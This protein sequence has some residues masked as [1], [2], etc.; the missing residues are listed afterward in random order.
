MIRYREIIPLIIAFLIVSPAMLSGAN[1][2]EKKTSPLELVHSD[3]LEIRQYDDNVILNLT[4]NVHFKQDST[5]IK[6]QRAVWYKTSGVV[7][8]IDSVFLDDGKGNTINSRRATYY[9]NS[10]KVTVS[11]DVLMVAD[12]GR[13]RITGRKGEYLRDREYAI[14]SGEP[15]LTARSEKDTSTV[16]ITARLLE[17][18]D[19]AR[20]GTATDTVKITKGK[21]VATGGKAE[22]YRDDEYAVLFD[23]PVAVQENSRL[24]G[25]TIWVYTAGEKVSNIAVR[26]NARGEYTPAPDSTEEKG[27]TSVLTGKRL[28]FFFTDEKAESVVVVETATSHYEP[29]SKSEDDVGTNDASGDTIKFYIENDDLQRAL[30]LGGAEGSYRFRPEDAPPDSV[31]EDT[32]WYNSGIIEYLA[33]D[34]SIILTGNSKV[35]YQNMNLISHRIIYNT[36]RDYVFAEGDSVHTADSSYYKDPPILSEGAE[37][38]V[39]YKM[40]YNIKSRKGR[41]TYGDTEFEGAYYSGGDIRKVTDEVLYVKD[42]IYT[43]CN[44]VEPHWS[45]KADKMKMITR[46]KV[47]ARPVI[48]YIGDLPVGALPYYVFPIKKGRH[49]GFT[50][51]ELGNFERGER[52][53]RNVGYYWAASEYWDLQG[54]LDYFEDSHTALNVVGRYAL[55]YKLT[56]RISGSFV[57]TSRYVGMTK[58]GGQRWQ[59]TGS[60]NQVINQTTT[61]AASGT[62]MSDR[63]FTQDISFDPEE[64]RNRNINSH[65]SLS[66]KYD[67]ASLTVA[68]DQNWNLDTD[69][70]TESLPVISYSRYQQAL[71]PYRKPR[72]KGIESEEQWYNRIYYRYTFNAR[73]YRRINRLE[74][75]D[76]YLEY[77]TADH[78]LGL[79]ATTKIA[80]VLNFTPGANYQETWYYIPTTG[81]AENAGL[82]T[83]TFKRRGTYN[84]GA[85][86]NTTLYGL[87]AFNLGLVDA[88]RHIITPTVSYSWSPE[89]ESNREYYSFTRAGGNP[90]KTSSM[91]IGLAN[92]FQM[93]GRLRGKEYK[94]DLF[95]VNMSTGYNFLAEGRKWSNL[96]TSIQA[97]SIKKISL[98]G[99][100]SHSFYDRDASDTSPDFLHPRLLNYALTTSFTMSGKQDMA[101]SD[102]QQESSQPQEVGYFQRRYSPITPT[103]SPWQ[104]SFSARYTESRSGTSKYITRWINV[105]YETPITP[106]W[107]IKYTCSYDVQNKVITDQELQVKRD[108]H[109]W[110]MSFIWRPTGLRAGYYLLINVIQLPEI[111]VETSEGGI[112][113]GFL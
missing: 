3:H 14:I 31:V 89:F 67:Q 94:L 63:K 80:G 106:G 21:L 36:A 52:F 99:S 113:G 71:F 35:I 97:T 41:I 47:F 95:K 75:N 68:L 105:N 54:T 26:G 2:A 48:L 17:Y 43:S 74:G 7:V 110:Q 108:L 33:G 64:I 93:K 15:K 55:R 82:E 32:V 112:R 66:K 1:G 30:I 62:F 18:D 6:S 59:V 27:S 61:L 100:M 16:T 50:T 38:I 83:N 29:S 28:D 98:S 45:F 40:E 102:Q 19:L 53:I 4:G 103:Q 73:N 70:R 86:A 78:K 12:S 56:G 77:A 13:V 79:S 42:G 72:Q 109:C 23:N 90:S 34:S 76:S 111:K 107:R 5:H 46:D 49:S 65:V 85:S 87:F 20:I 92:S 9:R 37:K 88:F 91:S 104:L 44:L 84:F 96:S 81:A 57:N 51:F 11:E 22:F 58:T 101:P 24:E 39:G 8:L 10:R 60:H 25:D 69:I